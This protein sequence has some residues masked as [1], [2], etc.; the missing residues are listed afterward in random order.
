AIADIL[1]R[2]RNGEKLLADVSD[3]RRRMDA[4]HHNEIPWK[5]KYVRGGL[6][7]LE[8]IAEYLQ[9]RH[10]AEHP[11]A[12]APNTV[13]AFRRLDAAGLLETDDT[14]ALISASL[15]MRRVRGMLRLTV[16]GI[17]VEH[18]SSPAL[19][20]ALARTGE[21][22]DFDDLRDKIMAAQDSVRSIYA[23]LIDE[24][25]EAL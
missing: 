23:R 11:D 22:A 13:E 18:Q 2:P 24:P 6:V 19:R 14:A 1:H 4:E 25:A 10:G 3:M 20:A 17:Q 9:L 7:D 16:D 8:F 21:A 5:T 15:L 12:T